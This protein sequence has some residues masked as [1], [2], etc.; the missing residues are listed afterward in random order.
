MKE[1]SILNRKAQAIVEL[2]VMASLMLL[3]IG[4]MCIFIAKLNSDQYIQM[5]SFRRA[6]KKSHDENKQIGYGMWDDRRMVD[7][8]MPIIGSKNAHSGAGF[9]M[10]CVNS[11]VANGD[12]GEDPEGELYVAINSPPA[13][14][15]FN[16]Y[17]VEGGS[18]GIVPEYLT[19]TAEN[20]SASTSGHS[21]SSS[22]SAG[23]GEFM[24][25]EIGQSMTVYQ[26][27]GYGG[28]RGLGASN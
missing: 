27:R 15:N 17:K 26:G 12:T 4:T 3:A 9:V 6:L 22:R 7:V 13:M 1:R 21:T 24:K 2:G 25:Y 10:W 20:V 14:M 8:N 18:G 19:F 5:E 28:G 16:E 23:V 11:V